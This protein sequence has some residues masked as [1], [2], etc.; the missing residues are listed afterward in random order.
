MIP[1]TV[2]A[3]FYT[4]SSPIFASEECKRYSLYNFTN[5]YGPSKTIPNL[6]IDNRMV[7]FGIH[8]FIVRHLSKPVTMKDIEETDRFM[9][10]SH[11]FYGKFNWDK[12]L[13]VKVV[14]KFGGYLPLKI[15]SVLD[16]DVFWPNEPVIEV[17]STED[18]FGELAVHIEA[19]LV[20]MVSYGSAVATISRHW[21]E[22]MK[23]QVTRD[24]NDLSRANWMIHNFGARACA[25]EE[26]SI[27]NGR[28]HLLSFNGTDNTDAAYTTWKDGCEQYVGT[29]I[30]AL[31][32]H[33]VLSYENENDCF[34]KLCSVSNVASYVIDTYNSHNAINHLV[35]LALDNPKKIIIA[36]PDSGNC[37]DVVIDVCNAAYE[38]GLFKIENGKIIPKNLQFIYGDSVT[39]EKSQIILDSLRRLG[40]N[41]T[42]WGIFGVGGYLVNTPT[43]DLFSSAY[44]L[45][46]S[47]D[48]NVTKISE[49]KSKMSIPGK[50]SLIYPATRITYPTKD[51]SSVTVIPYDPENDRKVTHYFKNSVN[52]EPY[53][54]GFNFNEARNRCIN[55]F[56]TYDS[57]YRFIGNNQNNISSEIKT[58]QLSGKN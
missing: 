57:S 46:K 36:R 17:E 3:D 24:G 39:P 53:I 33:S 56:N 41:A 43:R 11:S 45:A 28:A 58:I 40:Y 32:H 25:S 35:K 20:G 44:K 10:R 9:S 34:D 47:G 21:L 51:L 55:T 15:S 22:R 1:L 6:A 48:R 5:R 16:G 4:L 27:L 49:S 13:W 30:D 7:M 14:Q 52:S 23:E 37:P 54:I 19:R 26:E 8:D 38:A 29:S 2:S 18:G 31:A 50:N 42:R 12:E